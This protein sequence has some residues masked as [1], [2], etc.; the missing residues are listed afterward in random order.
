MT[1][2]KLT[3]TIR[4]EITQSY[5][6]L[7]AKYPTLLHQNFW[8]LMI[9]IFSI[10]AIGTA[11]YLWWA[12]MLP[13]WALFLINA[14][15]FGVLH[16]LEHDLIHWM[17]FKKQKVVHHTLIGVIWLLR[18]LTINPWM[19]RKLHYHHHKFSGSLHDVEERGVTN[20]ERWGFKRLLLTADLVVGGIFR[21]SSMLKDVSKEMKTGNL[22]L[23]QG[24]KLK[25]YAILG[26]FPI[27]IAAHVILYLFFGNIFLQFLD[28]QFN[29][30]V[31]LPEILIEI[32]NA[33]NAIIFIILLPNLIRQFSLHFITS[34]LHYFG[35]VEQGN[36]IEQTQI[37]NAWWTLPFQVFC[38][39]FGWTH[40]IHHFVVNETFYIRHL[41]R[42]KAHKIMKENGVRFNDLGTFRRANRFRA[43]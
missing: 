5:K 43:I 35:D 10:T 28:V 2:Q 13:T 8:G 11:S 25:Q 41:A 18:P 1:H 15:F 29:T 4:R 38:F 37:L 6:D 39:F 22:T 16:E 14:F 19:R 34:N 17:Y 40:A 33:S 27:T 30:G 12:N 9:F 42:K 36:V 20:G 7:K 31:H 21:A 26:L 23:F 32:L 3:S 24:K